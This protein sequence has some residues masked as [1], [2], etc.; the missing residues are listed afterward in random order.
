MLGKTER[1]IQI[2]IGGEEICKGELIWGRP[3]LSGRGPHVKPSYR[4]GNFCSGVFK[5]ETKDRHCLKEKGKQR[6]TQSAQETREEGSTTAGDENGGRRE[7]SC[8][9]EEGPGVGTT[10]N[11]QD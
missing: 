11:R 10:Q 9:G 8:A 6:K 1:R 3:R 7:E 5:T 4:E 2:S